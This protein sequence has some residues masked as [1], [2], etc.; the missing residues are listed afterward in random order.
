M[1]RKPYTVVRAKE[2]VAIRPHTGSVDHQHN[3]LTLAL[4]YATGRFIVRA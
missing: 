3:R 1:L 2:C 4:S